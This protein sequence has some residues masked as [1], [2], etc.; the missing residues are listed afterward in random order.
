MHASYFLANSRRPQ[1]LSF[2]HLQRV[3][4]S[5]IPSPLPVLCFHALTR[6]F[7]LTKNST[8]FFSCHC[9]LLVKNTGG[10]VSLL[11]F[12]RLILPGRAA[13]EASITLT[14]SSSLQGVAGKPSIIYSLR[15]CTV[16]SA[17][18][19]QNTRP[20]WKNHLR[21]PESPTLPPMKNGPRAVSARRPAATSFGRLLSLVTPY[22]LPISYSPTA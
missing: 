16:S 7:A 6:S 2:P 5:F 18:R 4:N 22:I 20:S 19:S 17:R 1:L 13:P 9:A 8:L 21:W 10:G 11:A 15:C 14:Q 3:C 12:F